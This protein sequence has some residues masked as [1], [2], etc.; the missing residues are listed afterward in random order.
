MT[1]FTGKHKI[2]VLAVSCLIIILS[3]C[4]SRQAETFDTE[5]LDLF[6]AFFRYKFDNNY[7][8]AQQDAQAY[9]LTIEGE[10]P[11]PEFLARFKEHSPPVKMGS[12]FVMGGSLV[13]GKGMVDGNG[14]LFRID[15]YK[16]IGSSKNRAEIVGGYDEGNLSWSGASYIWMRKKGKWELEVAGPILVG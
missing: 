16:W 15:S 10:D 9:F 4:N 1:L 8:G 7:S 6:E 2:C 12:E 3:S 14:L 11:S 5:T 13:E